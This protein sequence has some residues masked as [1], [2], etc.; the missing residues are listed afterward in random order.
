MPYAWPG[1]DELRFFRGFISTFSLIDM[2]AFS[3]WHHF[4]D[5][6]EVVFSF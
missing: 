5:D 6:A 1:T 2:A 3:Q 4:S